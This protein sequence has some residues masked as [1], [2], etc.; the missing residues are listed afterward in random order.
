MS[1]AT[2]KVRA[3]LVSDR[4]LVAFAGLLVLAIVV[5]AAVGAGVTFMRG[6]WVMLL[7]RRGPATQVF[8]PHGDNIVIGVSVLYRGLVSTFGLNPLPFRV[9]A[10]AVFAVASVLLFVWLRRRVGDVLAALGVGLTLLMGAAYQDL[11][12]PLQIGYVAAVASGL[13]ALLAIERNDRRGDLLACMLLVAGALTFTAGVAFVVG[14]AVAI[15]LAPEARR[16]LWIVAIPFALV[17]AWYLVWGRDADFSTSAANV[18]SAPLFL[19]EGF[20]SSIAALLGLSTPQNAASIAGIE[21]GRALLGVG[22]AVAVVR[23]VR[24]GRVPPGLWVAVATAMSFWLV[25]GV[26]EEPGRLATASRYTYPG[27]VFVLMITGELLA[28]VRVARTALNAIVVIVVIAVASS[29]YYLGHAA[30]RYERQGNLERAGLVAI[31]F[32]RDRV[33]PDFALQQ[34]ILGTGWAPIEAGPYLD[35]LDDY[36][37]SPGFSEA[38]L[39]RA[40]GYARDAADRTLGEILDLRVAA[41]PQSA[42]NDCRVVDPGPVELSPGGIQLNPVDGDVKLALGRFSG[43]FPVEMGNLSPG[44]WELA[45]PTDD[46]TRPWRAEFEGTSRVR[47]CATR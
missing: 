21:W 43:T 36:G 38:E 26:F 18:L 31:E 28:D 2:A 22:A 16:R 42:G 3:R 20:A 30:E 45:I 19:I 33:A 12:W 14:A 44:G 17:I 13:G 9:V 39:R 35:A 32:T 11:L 41:V 47:V 4:G 6:D 24:V 8:E 7:D 27:A 29:A 1:R 46:S 10:L 34:E 40:P 37:G 25:A 5:I 23:L 15:A